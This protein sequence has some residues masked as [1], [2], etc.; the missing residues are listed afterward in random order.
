MQN[1]E[2]GV[3][4][5]EGGPIGDRNWRGGYQTADRLPEFQGPKYRGSLASNSAEGRSKSVSA[6]RR[7]ATKSTAVSVI[8]V[9][10]SRAQIFLRG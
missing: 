5:G 7:C 3:L 4:L 2:G 9:S 10:N 6:Q 8:A 1:C